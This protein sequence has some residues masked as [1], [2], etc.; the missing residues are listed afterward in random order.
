MN[1]ICASCSYQECLA[2]PEHWNMNPRLIVNGEV[3]HTFSSDHVPLMVITTRPSAEDARVGAHLE[4]EP[5]IW[6]RDMLRTL[7]V[8]YLIDAAVRCY[9][10]KPKLNHYRKCAYHWADSIRKYRPKVILCL[11]HDPGKYVT[12]HEKMTLAQLR[13]GVWD[14]D[15][16]GHAC[17]VVVTDH[18][19]THS[20]YT[21]YERGGRDLRTEYKGMLRTLHSVLSG[22]YVST[23][24]EY[25]VIDDPD[26]NACRKA[27]A[28][29]QSG[30]LE[31]A[32]D[33]ETANVG[34]NL[35]HPDN[36]LLCFGLSYD[37]ASAQMEDFEYVNTVFSCRGWS[38]SWKTKVLS[39]ALRD[40]IA[41]G[42]YI[43]YD[44]QCAYRFTSGLCDLRS[45][46][47]RVHDTCFLSYLPNQLVLGNGLEDQCFSHLGIPRWKL[48]TEAE[49]A[50]LRTELPG[51]AVNYGH[52]PADFL[53]LYQARDTWA[54]LRVWLEYYKHG[55]EYKQFQYT[56]ELMINAMWGLLDIERN[57]IPIDT[58]RMSY[59]RRRAETI[60]DKTQHWLDNHPFTKAAG[61]KSLNVKSTLQKAKVAEVTK[62]TPKFVSATTGIP[63]LD[64]E[65]VARQADPKGTPVQKYWANIQAVTQKRDRLSKFI[66]PYETGSH[67]GRARGTYSL[68]KTEDAGG[69]DSGRI[70]CRNLPNNTL[71]K[72]KEV[73]SAFVAPDGFE[74]FEVDF[75]SAEPVIIGLLSACQK[76]IEI[77]SKKAADMNDPEG[78][79]YKVNASKFK[80]LPMSFWSKDNE[81][82]WKPVRQRFKS[83]NL[84]LNYMMGPNTMSVTYDV[85]VEECTEFTDWYFREYPEIQRFIALALKDVFLNKPVVSASGR[86]IQRDMQHLYDY[87]FD[88]HWQIPFYQLVKLLGITGEDGHW[89]RKAVNFLI[90]GPTSDCMIAQLAWFSKFLF[91]NPTAA[92]KMICCNVVHDSM[93]WLLFKRNLS[94]LAQFITAR[95]QNPKSYLPY[96]FKIPFPDEVLL[97]VEA[98]HGPTLGEME[99]MAYV[100]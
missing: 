9:G 14:I 15:F 22:S 85:P 53:H 67:G 11:G 72:D 81:K 83:L 39:A 88:A 7:G 56:Y 99:E 69:I 18:P 4:S 86:S 28:L 60:I 20:A 54:Q 96:K 80:K 97:M 45:I 17:K 62:I 87:D 31:V 82:V 26:S 50:R 79:L 32:Y 13:S 76:Y 58:E 78:D 68:T 36:E 52:L 93:W 59:L 3:S 49:L 5:G 75:S 74:F 100:L 23:D 57:G 84:G 37:A 25:E 90:Q 47:R 91:E 19:S 44:L 38:D 29:I 61:L 35:Y 40:K 34:D 98:A 41:I 33:V 55:P 63:S 10:D 2:K 8:T 94:K 71:Q 64:K 1:P 65:E 70:G 51:V 92:K 21:P 66:V 46:L 27:V 42:T 6:M 89:C 16:D 77:F 24:I 48:Y 43:Q 12:G 73:R 30:S 95:M